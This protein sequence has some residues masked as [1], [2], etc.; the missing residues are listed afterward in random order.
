[1]AQAHGLKWT[2]FDVGE[3]LLH[4]SPDFP[5]AFAAVCAREGLPVSADLVVE[6]AAAV[7]A[8]RPGALGNGYSF[9]PEASRAFWT[10]VYAD[11]LRMLGVE[12]DL[13]DAL[14]THF[15]SPS[16][17]ELFPDALPCLHACRAA[18]IRLGIVSN[19][20][21]W[22]M[23]FLRDRELLPLLEVTVVSGVEKLEKPDLA[24]YE[25]AIARSGAVAGEIVHVGD[26]PRDDV[27]PARALG[28]YAILLDRD[29]RHPD[30]VGPR[31]RSLDELPALLF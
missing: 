4:P 10:G 18:G 2:F 8:H 21:A 20:E 6:A 17:Y 22:L 15:S 27:A 28:L 13:A 3:T 16:S 5:R 14:Y 12:A 23:A 29:G 30:H 11:I 7:W 24:I 31:I 1:M 25:L 19:F 9:S 26:S